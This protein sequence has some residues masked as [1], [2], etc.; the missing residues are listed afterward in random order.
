MVMMIAI[1]PSLNAS[2]R[3]LCMF[4]PILLF[5]PTGAMVAAIAS[6]ASLCAAE[7]EMAARAGAMDLRHR[8][9]RPEPLD[10]Q[11]QANPEPTRAITEF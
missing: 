7:R 2:S 3:P 5:V 11:R 6:R 4:R 1:T 8:L 10:R 9:H